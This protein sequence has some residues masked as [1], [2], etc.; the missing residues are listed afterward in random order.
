MVAHPC[1]EC[2][3]SFVN[4]GALANHMR[5]GHGK[6]KKKKLVKCPE[7]GRKFRGVSALGI[8]RYRAHGVPGASTKVVA[9]V[10]SEAANPNPSNGKPELCFCPQCGFNLRVFI[11]ALRTVLEMSHE[12]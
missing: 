8:H 10:K 12:G 1:T 3:R 9:E 6:K 11:M 4:A 5:S 7:C 2:D